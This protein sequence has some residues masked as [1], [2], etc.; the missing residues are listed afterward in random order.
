MA[1]SIIKA[2]PNS[3]STF[4]KQYCADTPTPGYGSWTIHN[5][6]KTLRLMMPTGLFIPYSFG[7]D[8]NSETPIIDFLSAQISN[9]NGYFNFHQVFKNNQNE[10]YLTFGSPSYQGKSN[11]KQTAIINNNTIEISPTQIFSNILNEEGGTKE[12]FT[13]SIS[14]KPPFYP[15]TARFY[16]NGIFSLDF[17]VPESSTSNIQDVAQCK[18]LENVREYSF[19]TIGAYGHLWYTL[20]LNETKMKSLLQVIQ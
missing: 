6:G 20:N 3:W 18:T 14:S 9:S 7:K 11:S 4:I 5:D 10:K 15:C 1:E 16:T 2:G 13:D 19:M 17:R 8:L 12:S